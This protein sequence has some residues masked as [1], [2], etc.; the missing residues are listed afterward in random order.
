MDG[1]VAALVV[2]VAGLIAWRWWLDSRREHRAHELELR[3]Q[4][5]TVEQKTLDG[6]AGRMAS[7]EDEVKRLGWKKT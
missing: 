7:L 1:S 5:V 3:K 6:L 2:A 4:V